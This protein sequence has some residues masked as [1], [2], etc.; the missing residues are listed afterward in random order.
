MYYQTAFRGSEDILEHPEIMSWL[1]DMKPYVFG[2]P[3]LVPAV[4][5]K[6]ELP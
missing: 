4:V 5:R 2:M 3:P 1:G 6:R